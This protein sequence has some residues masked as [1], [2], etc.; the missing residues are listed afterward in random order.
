MN[1]RI[2]DPIRIVQ[3]ESTNRSNENLMAMDDKIRD[4]VVGVV[5]GTI[6]HVSGDKE[7]EVVEEVTE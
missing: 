5:K 1:E 6:K 2:Y 4:Y 7:P 3:E